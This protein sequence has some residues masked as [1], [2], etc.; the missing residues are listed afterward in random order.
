MDVKKLYLSVPK[1]EARKKALNARFY[2]SLHTKEVIKLIEMVLG[3][4]TFEFNSS[5][6][7]QIDGTAYGSRLGMN[8]VSTYM[9]EWERDLL[10]KTPKKPF[11]YFRFVD[12]MYGVWVHGEGDLVKFGVIANSIHERMKIKSVYSTKRLEFLGTVAN[13]EGEDKKRTLQKRD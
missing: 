6:Y 5:H 10:E 4:N 1:Q 8:Y 7:T 2:Q 12:D 11:L 13:K 9:S 3:H